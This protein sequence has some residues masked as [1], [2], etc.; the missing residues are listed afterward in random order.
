MR[1]ERRTIGWEEEE[2]VI[3]PKERADTVYMTRFSI[4][5]SREVLHKIFSNLY[6]CLFSIILRV[7]T[8][9]YYH[10]RVLKFSYHLISPSRWIRKLINLFLYFFYRRQLFC[11]SWNDHEVVTMAMRTSL[12]G[13]KATPSMIWLPWWLSVTTPLCM[14]KYIHKKFPHKSFLGLVRLV[15]RVGFICH[16]SSTCFRSIPESF[17]PFFPDPPDS[18]EMIYVHMAHTVH[19]A[20]YTT[21]MQSQRLC[22]SF[23]WTPHATYC[24][25]N[26]C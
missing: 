20:A 5:C 24:N 21:C 6:V 14:E 1:H 10:S 7:S 23:H 15:S 2:E 18:W 12:R 4:T 22:C 17:F 3:V 9:Y 26:V 8:S 13:M 11:C 16:A 19:V 25:L